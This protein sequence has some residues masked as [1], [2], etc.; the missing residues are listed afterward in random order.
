[1]NLSIN[2]I[3]LIISAVAAFFICCSMNTKCNIVG[4]VT[5]AHGTVTDGITGKPIANLAMEVSDLNQT[6]LIISLPMQM[7]VTTWSLMR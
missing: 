2:R 5:E 6:D 1:M 3:K 7:A 4:P